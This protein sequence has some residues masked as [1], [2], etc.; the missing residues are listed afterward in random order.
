MDAFK[1]I[2]KCFIL[3][4]FALV[5]LTNG[6][7]ISGGILFFLAIFSLPIKQIQEPTI[8]LLEKQYTESDKETT[9]I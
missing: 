9:N 7:T 2:F 5:G 3:F 6:C 1:K 4:L 8:K